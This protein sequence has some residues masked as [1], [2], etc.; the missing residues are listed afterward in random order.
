MPAAVRTPSHATAART[1]PV[2]CCL[3][4]QYCLMLQGLPVPLSDDQT[5]G[6]GRTVCVRMINHV[7]TIAVI[8]L[9]L[10]ILPEL[11]FFKI[12]ISLT[13][14]SDLKA[15][16]AGCLYSTT[17]SESCDASAY[18]ISN[19]DTHIPKLPVHSGILY[20]QCCSLCQCCHYIASYW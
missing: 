8:F 2:D 7:Q 16:G 12:P 17:V 4:S 13:A 3:H 19:C 15:R 20:C 6:P 1:P 5:S 9:V 10:E 18:D 14:A 11:L